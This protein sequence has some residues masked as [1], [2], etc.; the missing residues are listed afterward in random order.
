[1][2]NSNLLWAVTIDVVLGVLAFSFGQWL[3]A[4]VTGAF[5]FVGLLL[6]GL[7]YLVSVAIGVYLVVRGLG[8]LVEDIVRHEIIHRG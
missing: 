1:M 5:G 3:G 4:A 8:T 7:V 6:Y 2:V